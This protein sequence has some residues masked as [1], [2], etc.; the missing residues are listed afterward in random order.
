MRITNVRMAAS[1][2]LVQFFA[3]VF[4]LST[5]FWLVGYIAERSDI[6]LPYQLPVSALQAVCP[7]LAA[8]ICA[9]RRDSSSF[10][11]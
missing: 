11:F 10:T 5:P 2:P 4:A 8:S 1:D 7:V 3:L 9:A 6:G